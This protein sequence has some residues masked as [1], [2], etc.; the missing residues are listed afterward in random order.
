MNYQEAIEFFER[1]INL[2]PL[3]DYILAAK[4]ALDAMKKQAP[5]KAILQIKTD[6]SKDG[7]RTAKRP[8]YYCPE[9]KTSIDTHNNYCGRCGQ[10]IK[11]R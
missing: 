9:C 1:I 11:L 6:Y 10:K 7:T 2:T 5:K 4:L 8:I 3:N